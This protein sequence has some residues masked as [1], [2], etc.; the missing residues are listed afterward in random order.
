VPPTENGSL[1]VGVAR[2]VKIIEFSLNE[3]AY[4]S[5]Y[6]KTHAGGSPIELRKRWLSSS[7]DV[8]KQR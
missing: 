8:Q 4:F 2:M 6:F 7:P 5:R 3:T 1:E